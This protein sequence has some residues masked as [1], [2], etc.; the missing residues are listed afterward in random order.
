MFVVPLLPWVDSPKP[1][2]N[3]LIHQ[4]PENGHMDFKGER[5]AWPKKQEMNFDFFKKSNT[6]I[7]PT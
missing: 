5:L 4:Y 2:Y 7:P 1:F 3:F 6:T